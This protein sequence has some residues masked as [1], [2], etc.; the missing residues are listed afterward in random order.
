MRKILLC[1]FLTTAI[2]WV[3]GVYVVA[4]DCAKRKGDT[5]CVAMALA[6]PVTIPIA[7]LGR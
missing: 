5:E 2:L 3:L 1:L 4:I 7:Y 6:W